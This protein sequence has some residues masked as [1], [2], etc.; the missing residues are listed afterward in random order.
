MMPKGCPPREVYQRFPKIEQRGRRATR[1]CPS[2]YSHQEPDLP[3]AIPLKRLPFS[4]P[5]KRSGR[6]PHLG[7]SLFHRQANLTLAIDVKNLDEDFIALMQNIRHFTH[8]VL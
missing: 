3:G 5:D 6:L 4:G 8:P 2:L 1:T 7:D